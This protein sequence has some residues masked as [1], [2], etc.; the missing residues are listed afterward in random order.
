MR[1][2]LVITYL[3]SYIAADTTPEELLKAVSHIRR[4]NMNLDVL[5]CFNTVFDNTHSA[6]QYQAVIL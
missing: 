6:V 5:W 1:T 3:E 4:W 2:D